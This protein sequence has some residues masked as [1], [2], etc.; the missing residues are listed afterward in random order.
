VD[1]AE[2]VGLLPYEKILVG[3][4]QM[5]NGLKRTW[6]TE[7]PAWAHRIERRDRRSADHYELCAVNA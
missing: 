2:I 6:Y 7:W 3:N 4:L 1:I 5:E